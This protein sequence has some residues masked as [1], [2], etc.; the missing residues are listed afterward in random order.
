MINSARWGKHLLSAGL[1]TTMIA[2]SF[3]VPAAEA[4]SISDSQ[5]FPQSP[6]RA[7]EV[8][9]KSTCDSDPIFFAYYRTWRDKAITL[10]DDES[11]L[12]QPQVKLTDLPEGVNFVSLFHVPSNFKDDANFWATFKNEYHPSLKERNIKVVRTIDVST[13]LKKA[14]EKGLHGKYNEPS[15]GYRDAAREIYSQFVTANN[16]DG[17]DIDMEDHDLH[18]SINKKWQLRHMM[19]ALSEIAGPQAIEN[20]GRSQNDPNYKYLIFDTPSDSGKYQVGLVADLVDYVLVQTYRETETPQAAWNDFRD[21]VNSCQFLVGYSNPEE[22]DKT[23]KG[24]FIAGIGNPEKSG[25]VGRA[26]WQPQNGIKAGTFTYAIDRD[27]STYEEPSYSRLSPTDFKFAQYAIV[28]NDPA[29]FEAKK[30]S[31]E[32]KLDSAPSTDQAAKQTLRVKITQ[33]PTYSA[34]ADAEKE[35]DKLPQLPETMN[36]QS[37]APAAPMNTPGTQQKHDIG[38]PTPGTEKKSSSSLW[39]ILMTVTAGLMAIFGG[40]FAM[41]LRR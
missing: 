24:Q 8:G 2:S 11:P 6:G 32:S 18:K 7:K 41:F 37:A 30:K 40:F 28:A 9:P 10:K 27:G 1:A 23:N 29:K 17:L 35:I 26:K 13:L 36:Q 14:T 15:R 4:V 5:P 3:A 21:K 31:I 33:A 22:N 16:L 39:R 20:R 25:A 34:L 12:L 19:T 38:T